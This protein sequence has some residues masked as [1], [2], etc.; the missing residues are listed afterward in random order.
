M[1]VDKAE[2]QNQCGNDRVELPGG[3]SIEFGQSLYQM[4]QIF[5]SAHLR[6]APLFRDFARARGWTRKLAGKFDQL[7][8]LFRP[9]QGVGAISRT[10]EHGPPIPRLRVPD[11]H[12]SAGRTIAGRLISIKG[13]GDRGMVKSRFCWTNWNGVL[14]VSGS[15]QVHSPARIPVQLRPDLLLLAP[16]E[17]G[18]PPCLESWGLGR[19]HQ[20]GDGRLAPGVGDHFRASSFLAEQ[21]FQKVGGAARLA[22]FHRHPQMQASKSSWKPVTAVSLPRPDQIGGTGLLPKLGRPPWRP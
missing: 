11:K 3:F 17:A 12:P 22:V 10:A 16:F 15:G 8:S 7:L 13:A 18:R 20:L 14:P 2:G 5:R 1:D 21:V 9:S 4:R 19:E 6:V